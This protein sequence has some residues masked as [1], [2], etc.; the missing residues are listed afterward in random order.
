[1][2][3]EDQNKKGM[4]FLAG[5]ISG[6]L[7]WVIAFICSVAYITGDHQTIAA[8]DLKIQKFEQVEKDTND[9]LIHM[10]DDLKNIQKIVDK[11]DK[12]VNP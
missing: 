6:G 2:T 3:R 1:M 8:D 4:S 9:R 12:K 7:P 5:F 10:E 11:I